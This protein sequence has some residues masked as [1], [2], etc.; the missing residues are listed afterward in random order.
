MATALAGSMID[1]LEKVHD[2]S[3]QYPATQYAIACKL[4]CQGFLNHN[5]VAM[6]INAVP[7]ALKKNLLSLY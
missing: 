7:I 2:A 4:Y 3:I 5:H 6:G 1:T